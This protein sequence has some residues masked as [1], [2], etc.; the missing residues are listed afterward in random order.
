MMELEILKQACK[1]T[2]QAA[3]ARKL[4]YSATTVNL[5]L[6]DKYTGDI[7]KVYRT[8]KVRL[9]KSNVECPVLGEISSSKCA[10][11]QA[12][13]FSTANAQRVQLFKSCRTCPFN[14]KRGGTQ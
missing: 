3:V 2:S 11:E 5:V 14:T 1:E 9:G 6:K 13:P 12:K 10:E 8:I 4:G 7:E